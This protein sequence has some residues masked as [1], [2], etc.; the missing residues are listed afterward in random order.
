MKLTAEMR[1]ENV[2]RAIRIGRGPACTLVR[3]SGELPKALTKPEEERERE[4]RG[5]VTKVEKESHLADGL[6]RAL[7]VDRS[8]YVITKKSRMREP[9]TASH[10]LR[11]FGKN[12][13]TQHK[14]VGQWEHWVRFCEAQAIC[15][16]RGDIAANSGTGRLGYMREVEL[17]NSALCFYMGVAK[18]RGREAALPGAGMNWLLKGYTEGA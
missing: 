5:V 6:V 1:A 15:P 9:I 18:G 7:G 11:L 14:Q 17:L 8:R 16:T 12:A 4:G 2:K 10:D 3:S 13:A